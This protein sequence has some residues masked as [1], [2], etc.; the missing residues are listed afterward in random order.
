[1]KFIKYWPPIF[2]W[3]G[4]IFIF[5]SLPD[6]KSDLPSLFDFILRKAAHIFEYAVLGFL[7][8]R[9]F[10]L[11]QGYLAKKAFVFS[12]LL[13]ALY[14]ASDEWHQTFILN[15]SGEIKDVFIDSFGALLSLSVLYF[16]KKE[17]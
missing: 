9:A 17:D 6:L 15:R 16:I 7:F 8:F 13:S 10:H 4:V 5:S 11:G 14:A 3:L 2:V 1:M 12:F